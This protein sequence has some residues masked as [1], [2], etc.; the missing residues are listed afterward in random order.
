MFLKLIMS[1]LHSS[2]FL[3]PQ[4]VGHQAQPSPAQDHPF[5]IEL[6][7]SNVLHFMILIALQ[8]LCIKQFFLGLQKYMLSFKMHLKYKED[9]AFTPSNPVLLTPF[10]TE[11]S[12]LLNIFYGM[13]SFGLFGC[14]SNPS[15]NLPLR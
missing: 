6:P 10:C 3:L 15:R 1:P 13:N 4:G 9:Y 8:H 11:P 12:A 7:S 5:P 2:S 14:C